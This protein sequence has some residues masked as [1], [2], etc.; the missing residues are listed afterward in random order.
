MKRLSIF[1]KEL[2]AFISYLNDQL[3]KGNPYDKRS[4]YREHEERES[5]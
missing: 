1:W 2:R 3:E 5:E 4:H